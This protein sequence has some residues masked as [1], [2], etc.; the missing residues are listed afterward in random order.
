[1]SKTLIIPNMQHAP[2]RMDCI[3]TKNA[4]LQQKMTQDK[5]EHT[6]QRETHK[7]KTNTQDK[8]KHRRQ[9][10]TH[11]TKMKTRSKE[12]HTRRRQ[13]HKKKT[14]QRPTHNTEG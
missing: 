10:Q 14:Q 13:T 4:S 6:Q 8:D 2:I 12:K 7:T 9:R 5:D 3:R 11:K 1:M